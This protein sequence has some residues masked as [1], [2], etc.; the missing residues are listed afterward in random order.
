MNEEKNFDV[1][2][3]EDTYE[4]APV[5]VEDLKKIAD[6]EFKQYTVTDWHGREIVVRYTIMYE[7]MENFVD[8]VTDACFDPE[9]GEFMP[10]NRD[11]MYKYCEAVF[12]TNVEL[13]TDS[14]E[15]YSLLYLV[16]LNDVIEEHASHHQIADIQSAIDAKI[17]YRLDTRLDEL[18]ADMQKVQDGFRSLSEMTASIDPDDVRSALDAISAHGG[19]DEE[20]IV[21]AILAQKAN[22]DVDNGEG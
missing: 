12:F 18:K 15:A 20:K 11:F 13:P 14:G 3:T 6:T 9:S 8:A 7:E 19:I 1:T 2:A 17:R 22:G 16:D 21:N 10:A 5:S 4:V